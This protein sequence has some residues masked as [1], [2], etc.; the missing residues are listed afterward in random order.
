M[1]KLK[2]LLVSLVGLVVVLSIAAVIAIKTLLPEDKVKTLVT[3]YAR[4]NLNREVTFDK[5]SFKFI[6]IDLKN[7]KMSERSTLND[8]I[9]IKADDFIVKVSPLPLLAKKIKISRI[10]LDS[11]DIN[12]TKDENGLFNFDDIIKSFQSEEPQQEQKPEENKS[13]SSSSFDLNIHHFDIKN[14]N[15]TYIDKTSNLDASI[16][17][18]NLKTKDFS[19]D[20]IFGC[21]TSFDLAVKQNKLDIALPLSAKFKTNLNNFDM[22]KLY[23]DVETFETDFNNATISLQGKIENIN[24]PKIDCNLILKNIDDQTFKDFFDCK[25]KFEA[26]EITFKTKSTINIS[27]M[28]A[29][30]ESLS[31]V[32]PNSN[33]DLAGTI[34]WGKQDVEYNL[35]LDLNLLIDNFAK[36]IPEYNL[37]GRLKT[38][39]EATQNFCEGTFAFENI[40]SDSNFGKVSNL[41][42]DIYLKAENPTP[43]YKADF[44][45]LDIE[46][47]VFNI[48]QLSL[49]YNDAEISA[50]GELTKQLRSALTLNLKSKNITDSTFKSFY[51]SPVKFIVP[52]LDIDTILS[53]NLN[54]KSADIT[55]LNIKIPDS[56]ANVTGLLN[57]KNEKNF[58]YNLALNLNLLL[59]NIAKNFPEYK[60]K[61]KIVSDAKVS[62]NDFSGNL[63]CSNVSF[64]Y[65]PMAT[66]SKLNIDAVA[67]SKKNIVIKAINGIF[68]DGK[69]E[70]NGSLINKD[71]KLNFNM[72]KLK[73]V[74][75]TKADNKKE[76]KKEEKKTTTSS[77]SS[78]SSDF[79][80]NIYTDITINEINVPYLVSKKATL[81]T[82]LKTVTSTCKKTNGTFALNIG[83][84]TISN[85]NKLTENKI[86][87]TF[88][89]LFNIVN[90]N[91]TEETKA[92]SKND[93]S[94]QNIAC[95]VLFTDGVI[96]TNDVSIKI[97]TAKIIASGTVDMKTEALNLSVTAGDYTG[98]KIK[99]TMSDPKVSYDVAAAVVS[100]L[101]DK[102][103]TNALMGLF[104]K[105]NKK[106]ETKQQETTQ[107]SATQETT[108]SAQ[109]E[110]ATQ[111]E[112]QAVAQEETKQ[113]TVQETKQE[114]V[115]TEENSNE[116]L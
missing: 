26:D 53:F 55:K 85:V 116:S 78:S 89:L 70:G 56:S 8:G 92:N 12:I 52:T 2:I 47:L 80:Y 4:N 6:G 91:R 112:T 101:G 40:S 22:D 27:S 31:L 21:E 14:A 50:V 83:A 42:A 71:I 44:S 45:T 13:S 67:K 7:F 104:G 43:L 90:N 18:F 37:T 10:L 106:E 97:P 11:I 111:Q 75:D 74:E 15:I 17:N 115:K 25:T 102:N 23:L 84:G 105:S 98:M 88:L 16:K 58:V 114:E 95:D 24:A 9:F 48:K 64:E 59:D 86:A 57:W 5:L 81:K 66:V 49:K 32:L 82:A 34:D 94:F 51:K 103:V 39:V 113:E 72:D 100:A 93:I 19:L 79:N 107:E 28:N 3:D 1:K 87:K 73:I 30:I 38:N 60:M 63:N 46:S 33:A 99:G 76:T 69:F 35:K 41:N 68:N 62:N 108:T 36:L 109:Q 65:L 110:T 54:T 77:S 61:G 96:K 29:D 20:D